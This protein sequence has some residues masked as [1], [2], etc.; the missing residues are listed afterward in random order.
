MHRAGARE[1][2]PSLLFERE[3]LGGK[4]SAFWRRNRPAAKALWTFVRIVL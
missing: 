2:R 3:K 4:G 1:P